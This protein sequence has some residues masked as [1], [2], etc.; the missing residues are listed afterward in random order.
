MI[1]K[2]IVAKLVSLVMISNVPLSKDRRIIPSFYLLPAF[3]C[4]KAYDRIISMKV[5]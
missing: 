2:R 5:K 4:R 3:P 1:A